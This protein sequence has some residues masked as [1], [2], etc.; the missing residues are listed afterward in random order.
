[1]TNQRKVYGDW[2]LF[3]KIIKTIAQFDVGFGLV[4]VVVVVVVT[5]FVV[6][7]EVEAQLLVGRWA[8]EYRQVFRHHFCSRVSTLPMMDM[9]VDKY[10]Y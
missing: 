7:E 3:Q 2:R 9:D 4:V 1:L 10:R 6:C 8:S 5:V